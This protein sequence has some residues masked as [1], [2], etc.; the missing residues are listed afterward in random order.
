[1]EDAGELGGLRVVVAAAAVVKGAGQ[2][3]VRVGPRHVGRSCSPKRCEAGGE[4]PGLG[5]EL[6]GEAECMGVQAQVEPTKVS[7]ARQVPSGQG[8]AL[9]MGVSLRAHDFGTVLEAVGEVE[10]R[11]G[12]LDRVLGEVARD[13][14]EVRVDG[15]DH[16]RVELTSPPS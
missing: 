15:V 10:G 12:G 6:S 4:S 3:Q 14:T 2:G 1:M 13:P 11:V 9:A 8:D 5:D 16:H 7:F